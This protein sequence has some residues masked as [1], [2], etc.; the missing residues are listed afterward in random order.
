VRL[1][2]SRVLREKR[3]G[4]VPKGSSLLFGH[5]ARPGETLPAVVQSILDFSAIRQTLSLSP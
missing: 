2:S 3:L 4:F 5:D 1:K